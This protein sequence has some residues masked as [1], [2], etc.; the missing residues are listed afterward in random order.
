MRAPILV[1]DERQTHAECDGDEK[2]GLPAEARR[3]VWSAVASFFAAR[4]GGQLRP[5]PERRLVTQAFASWNYILPVLQRIDRLC[6]RNCTPDRSGRPGPTTAAAEPAACSYLYLPGRQKTI[7]D[8][9]KGAARPT[10]SAAAGCASGVRTLPEAA[11]AQPSRRTDEPGLKSGLKSSS[12]VTLT[13]TSWNQILICLTRLAEL[14]L[15]QR[16]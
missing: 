9:Q 7:R 2:S 8:T 3:G 16:I 6:T 15:L 5:E 14:H 13:F 12:G 4:H 1:L 10:Q 11:T